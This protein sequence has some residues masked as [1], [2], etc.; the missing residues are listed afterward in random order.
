VE[1]PWFAPSVYASWHQLPSSFYIY[2][3]DKKSESIWRESQKNSTERATGLGCVV[4]RLHTCLR[5]AGYLT[6][7]VT[8]VVFDAVLRWCNRSLF[9]F[10]PLWPYISR[11]VLTKGERAAW[12]YL[13]QADVKLRAGSSSKRSKW[14]VYVTI[15]LG[16]WTGWFCKTHLALVPQRSLIKSIKLIYADFM[17]SRNIFCTPFAR[18]R[19]VSKCGNEYV[20][21]IKNL[22][23]G[24]YCF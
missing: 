20:L 6:V 19:S 22:R 17:C 18:N 10:H 23:W 1:L 13:S 21:G 4:L 14:A 24:Q 3:L 2:D 15:V 5:Q 9:G 12:I 8:V 11:F 16:E 7:D